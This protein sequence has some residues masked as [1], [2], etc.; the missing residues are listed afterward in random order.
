MF[1]TATLPFCDYHR[2]SCTPKSRPG[3]LSRKKHHDLSAGTASSKKENQLIIMKRRE[4]R[5]QTKNISLN[6]GLAT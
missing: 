3:G 6:E 2:V 4:K 1:T 5:R